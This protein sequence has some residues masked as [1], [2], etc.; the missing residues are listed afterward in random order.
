MISET[1]RGAIG[2]ALLGLATLGWPQSN[3]LRSLEE[4][5]KRLAPFHAVYVEEISV[6]VQPERTVK[7]SV[8]G[9]GASD[10]KLEVEASIDGRFSQLRY[11]KVSNSGGPTG[12]IYFNEPGKTWDFIEEGL[13]GGFGSHPSGLINP[14]AAAYEIESIEAQK[15]ISELSNSQVSGSM[16]QG[17]K[18]GA[19]KTIQLRTLGTQTVI[20]SVSSTCSGK[21]AN[22]L[23]RV[24]SWLQHKESYFPKSL[25][26]TFNRNGQVTQVRRYRLLKILQSSEPLRVNLVEGALL[27]NRDTQLVYD[28]KNGKLVPNKDFNGGPSST[29]FRRYLIIVAFI[30]M[31]L[32]E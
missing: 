16:I 8:L 10:S 22:T 25:S 29:D 15:Y 6:L 1:L 13:R 17:L 9:W 30:M 7:G 3:P 14:A 5:R 32:P 12:R 27:K 18:H 31:G 23:M 4:S 19:T 11:A 26:L 20:E 21:G 28:V 24:E 2:M